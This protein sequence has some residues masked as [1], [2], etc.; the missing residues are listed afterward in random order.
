MAESPI[1]DIRPFVHDMML[2]ANSPAPSVLPISLGQSREGRAARTRKWRS[3]QP[4]P[5]PHDVERCRRE[6]RLEMHLGLTPV[7]GA[8]H[9]TPVD[10][11][12]PG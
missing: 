8:T 11:L 3:H 5:H 6:H 7:A 1:E 10:G 12:R 4:F 9:P 2:L